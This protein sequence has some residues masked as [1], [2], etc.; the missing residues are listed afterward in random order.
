L[1][2]R[3]SSRFDA[4]GFVSWA[5]EGDTRLR[6]TKH[7]KKTHQTKREGLGKSIE[8]ALKKFAR[9]ALVKRWLLLTVVKIV[10][11]LA[12]RLLSDNDDPNL[13]S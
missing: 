10:S 4:V 1:E 12:K 5:T 13:S 9:S 2:R 8:R 3:A 11:W 6:E 7:M